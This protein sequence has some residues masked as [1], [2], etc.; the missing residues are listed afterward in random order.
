MAP[1]LLGD[2]AACDAFVSRRRCFD[3]GALAR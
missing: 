3:I 2:Q 1:V